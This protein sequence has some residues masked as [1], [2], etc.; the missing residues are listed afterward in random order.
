VLGAQRWYSA[1][2]GTRRIST[3]PGS[4]PPANRTGHIN[5]KQAAEQGYYAESAK[6]EEMPW[7]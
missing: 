5:L 1:G 2:S 3:S 6:S 4:G 7:N